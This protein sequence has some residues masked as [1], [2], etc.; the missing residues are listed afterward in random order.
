MFVIP[1]YY[2]RFFCIGGACQSTCCAQWGIKVDEETYQYYQSVPGEFGDYLRNNL[3]QRD[4]GA[5]IHVSSETACPFLDENGLCRIYQTLGEE[6]MSNTCKQFPRILSTCGRIQM[7]GLEISCEEVLRLVWNEKDPIGLVCECEPGES[8][9]TREELPAAVVCMMWGSEYLQDAT[10]PFCISLG[11]FVYICQNVKALLTENDSRNLAKVLEGVPDVQAQISEIRHTFDRVQL[12]QTAENVILEVVDTFY[13][14]I[15]ESNL[16]SMTEELWDETALGRTDE[17][18]RLYVR[19]CLERRDSNPEHMSFM[20][21]LAAAFL[22]VRMG[23]LTNDEAVS[24]WFGDAFLNYMILAAVLPLGWHGAF[25]DR[26]YF[27][28]LAKLGRVFEHSSLIHDYM[29]SVLCDVFHLD[30]M[31]YILGFMV[32]FDVE[33]YGGVS[34]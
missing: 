15:R 34:G 27:A 13:V 10:I 28:K 25:G 32:L 29:Q 23:Q 7:L 3:D 22:Q 30:D 14:L 4:E 11:A 1:N 8:F 19:R 20:R 9:P 2:D 24:Y 6:H 33:T 21:R 12:Y 5:F 17:E 16:S 31:S 18:H 26:S